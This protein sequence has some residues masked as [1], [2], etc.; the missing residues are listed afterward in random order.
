[1]TSPSVHTTYS[2]KL[3]I[4]KKGKTLLYVK[5]PL[6]KT[7]I[8]EAKLLMSLQF[9]SIIINTQ[10]EIPSLGDSRFI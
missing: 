7:F 3:V 5:D 1:M 2:L 10:C 6:R 8:K 4:S 9:K